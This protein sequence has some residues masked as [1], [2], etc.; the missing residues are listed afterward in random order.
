MCDFCMFRSMNSWISEIQN[1]NFMI[2]IRITAV[3]DNIAL[4]MTM[5]MVTYLTLKLIVLRQSLRLQSICSIASCHPM[6]LIVFLMIVMRRKIILHSGVW[7]CMVMNLSVCYMYS[8][9]Y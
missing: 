7:F 1:L 2:I 9:S 6:F 8:L 4:M 3:I 5:M